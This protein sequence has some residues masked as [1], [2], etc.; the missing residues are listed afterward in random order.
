M[1]R[2]RSQPW[3]SGAHRALEPDVGPVDEHGICECG[4]CDR[5]QRYRLPW[6]VIG[7]DIAYCEYHVAR[8]REHNP[9][10][11]GR[12]RR[13]DGVDDPGIYATVGN[14]FLTLNE[15]PREIAVGG[16]KMR[17]VALGVDGWALFDSAEPDQ[18]G[19]VRFVTVDRDLEPRESVEIDRSSAGDFV[20]WFREH[21][22]VHDL[23]PDARKALYGGEPDVE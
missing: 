11:W 15:V 6:P 21:E 5:E 3:Y 19:L 4:H 10:I 22:G 1:S 2:P 7:G 8:Y 18:D 14:R 13:L 9:E 17:R 23:D 12:V 16:E 20:S